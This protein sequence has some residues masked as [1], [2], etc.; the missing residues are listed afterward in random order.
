MN[1]V[2]SGL[3]W[4]RAAR[5]FLKLTLLMALLFGVMVATD[6]MATV[7]YTHLTL[8]TMAVV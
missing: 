5:H 2:K 4:G 1:K 6:T 7:S 3:Y 8:P